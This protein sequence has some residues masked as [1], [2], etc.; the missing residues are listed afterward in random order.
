[1]VG[2]IS[3][4]LVGKNGELGFSNICINLE[5]ISVLLTSG[6][7]AMPTSVALWSRYGITVGLCYLEVPKSLL[8]PINILRC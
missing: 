2:L 1:M 8:F 3:L 6:V 4:L 5:S 7:L